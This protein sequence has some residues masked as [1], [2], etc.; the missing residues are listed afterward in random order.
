MYL[1]SDFSN[2][3]YV[4]IEADGLNASRIWC[5]VFIIIA[6]GEIH[7]CV[8]HQEIKRFIDE[9]PKATIWVGH[10]AISFDVPTLNRLLDCR[11]D[12]GRVVDTLVLSYLYHAHMDGGHSLAAYG[13]RF[14]HPKGDF[15]DFSKFSY[16]MLAYC[17]NDCELGVKIFKALVAK[18]RKVGYSER[19]CELEHRIRVITDEQQRRGWYFDVARA[20]KLYNRL[21]T[22][23]RRLE[24]SIR[25]LFPPVLKLAGTYPFRVKG[26]GLPYASYDRHVGR[27]PRVE[28]RLNADGGEEYDVYDWQ[29]FNI[30]SVPQ[31][32]ERLQALGYNPTG[33]T[34]KGNPKVDEESL[35]AFAESSGIPQVQAIANYLVVNGRANMINTWLNNVGPDSR[36]HGSVFTCGA[37]SRRMTHS[38]PNT[39]NVPGNEARFGRAVRELWTVHDTVTRCVVGNDAKAIQ[40]RLFAHFLN[41]K[42]TADLYVYGDPHQVNADAAG[43]PRKPMKN[44]FYA[45]LFGAYDPKLATTAGFIGSKKATQ[46]EGERIR[47]ALYERTPGL[48]RATSDAQREWRINKGRL[49]CIDGGFVVCPSESA[50]FNYKIQPAEAVVMKQASVFVDERTRNLD[51]F[52]IGDIHDEHQHESAKGCA[53]ELGEIKCQAIRDAGEEFNLRV[54]MD[55]EFKVGRSWAQTH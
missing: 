39:A 55:G 25:E 11:I 9:A 24:E 51:A 52:K 54:P 43:Y 26:D 17:I 19:S 38:G 40:G 49:S 18:M 10:N 2:Y 31:R 12:Y 7:R 23:E 8:G 5:A 6:T 22:I 32:L 3:I 44:V 33:K 15:H 45:M 13:V 16:E 14:K 30:G 41:D 48:E 20:E 37:G 4:D 36:M 53:E 34:P 28:R 35:V 27:Y 21:R 1:P 50:A 29:E 46:A 47:R 42:E